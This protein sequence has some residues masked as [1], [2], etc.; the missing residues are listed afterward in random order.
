Q[1]AA[2]VLQEV[3]SLLAHPGSTKVTFELKQQLLQAKAAVGGLLAGSTEGTPA[4][5]GGA[6]AGAFSAALAASGGG[7]A[8]AAAGHQ[9]PLM[10][11]VADPVV[12]VRILLWMLN[13]DDPVNLPRGKSGKLT[14]TKGLEERMKQ[15]E[16]CGA[17]A[18][19]KALGVLSCAG[20]VVRQLPPRQADACRRAAMVRHIYQDKLP[21]L[22]SEG[23]LR[24]LLQ[25]E[26]PLVRVLAAM[27]AAGVALAPQVLRDQR[28]PLEARLRQLAHKAH[29]AAGMTF[30][31]NSPK[32]V[33]EVLF[34]HLGLP[35][36]PCAFTNQHQKHP[37]TKKEVLEELLESTQH[38][39]LRPLLDYRSLHKLLTGFVETLYSTAKGQWLRQ[40][41]QQREGARA[42]VPDVVRL[43]GTWLHTSTATGRLAMDEPNLQT[44]P[45][46]VQYSFQLSQQSG[47]PLPLELGEAAP[48]AEAGGGGGGPRTII[49]H[50]NL[51][52]AF[53]APPGHLVL[54]A[55]YKQ[56]ELRLMA[57]FSGDAALCALLRN[58]HQDPFVLLAAEWKRVPVEQV[59]PETRVQAKR[60]AY[61]MLYGMGTTTLA[62]ELGVSVGEAA[63]LSDNFRRAIP[64]VDR[65]TKE[66]V[67]ECRS[68][69]FVCTLLGRRRYFPRINERSSKEARSQRAQAE[70]QAVNSVCQGSA[71]DLVKAA[72]ITLQRRL[73]QRGLAGSARLVLMVHDELVLEVAAEQLPAVAALV[74]GVLEG[75]VA[76]AVPL[77]VKL[78]VGPSWGQLQ[79]Y[80]PPAVQ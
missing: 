12:D 3:C 36:P 29:V 50:F 34:Q 1:E 7:A 79:E 23:L 70:R 69:G 9:Q 66:V 18:H 15:A 48:G 30:D 75:E 46:P 44:I 59:T 52:T 38:P 20:T 22:Q 49:M 40:Q 61:G 17:S 74:R 28:A 77:P 71:A 35:P 4:L 47:E 6:G 80:D 25:I 55:D 43:C 2:A 11:D 8:G 5:A 14:V 65:W 57:H 10:L 27:E 33:S 19:A 39:I 67:E 56:I 51:R 32:D 45:R 26:M 54:T 72:M 63:E 76:L 68:C 60:L 58:P 53:V 64:G 41:Q 62:A 24:P 78:S 13:P 31:L 73:E 37:S 42:P 16:V 21:R